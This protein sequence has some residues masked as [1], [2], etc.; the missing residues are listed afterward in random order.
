MKLPIQHR[1]SA[2]LGA[3]ALLMLLAVFG[4]SRWTAERLAAAAIEQQ[5]TER[6]HEITA[7]LG[8]MHL[9]LFVGATLSLALL[10]AGFLLHDGEVARRRQGEA[11]IAALNVELRART[12]QLESV[13]KE[14][15]AFGYSVSHDLRAPLRHVRGFLEMLQQQNSVQDEAS[16]RLLGKIG[17]AAGRMDRLIED[18]LM[19]SRTGRAELRR[20]PVVLDQ[21]VA[22]LRAEQA[23]GGGGP[24]IAWQVGPLPTVQG[25]PTLLRLALSNLLS[26]AIKYSGKRSEPC[27]E[28]GSTT[29][30]DGDAVVFVRDN[31]VG[32]DMR[33]AHKLFG[34]FQRLHTAE[35]F[36]GTGIGLATVQR[37]I[38]RHGGRIWAEG[39]P[40]LGA[41]FYFSLPRCSA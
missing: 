19:F 28:V 35:Q 40:D 39:Q 6:A 24:A 18:L 41:T 31:G 20:T 16:R 7:Y 2:A 11:R 17:A 10:V 27:I 21:L 12:E 30:T 37:V 14:L 15:E 32:F 22:Q 5:P 36:E 29:G 33:Y 8:R 23:D 34:V 3:A 13:N 26:N 1:A 4:L 38:H 9:T 25:D